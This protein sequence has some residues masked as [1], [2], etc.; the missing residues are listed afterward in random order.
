MFIVLNSLGTA[1]ILWGL[2]SV[3]LTKVLNT[4][5]FALTFHPSSLFPFLSSS[6]LSISFSLPLFLAPSILPS[7]HFLL[8]SFLSFTL[9]LSL[10]LPSYLFLFLGVLFM[11]FKS[12]WPLFMTFLFW[13]SVNSISYFSI[14]LSCL[15]HLIAWNT[16]FFWWTLSIGNSW[17]RVLWRWIF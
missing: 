4:I 15:L 7:L 9:W 6:V 8:P 16:Q 3:Y 10:C 12:I 14:F 13:L 2:I 11:Y 5:F 1:V 17:G